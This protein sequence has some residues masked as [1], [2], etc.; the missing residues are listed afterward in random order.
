MKLY[1]INAQIEALTDQIV[2]DPETGEIT[3][4]TEALIEQ[5]EALHMERKEVLE[6]LAKVV[7]NL[8]SD[9]EAL[10][11]EMARLAKRATGLKN[12]EASIMNVLERECGGEKTDLG[13]A[14]VRYTKGN[15][16]V[17]TDPELT[18]DWLLA[19][20][21]GDMIR[22]SSPTLDKAGVK[23]L[24]GAGTAVPGCAIGETKNCT[25]K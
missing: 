11:N 6:Y 24:I 13:V 5:V 17:V 15:P 18:M 9:R 8:R 23:R 3:A 7:L 22:Y 12:R 1:E 10:E 2:V 16:L 14:T 4:D 25:L 20:G 19:H 21:H